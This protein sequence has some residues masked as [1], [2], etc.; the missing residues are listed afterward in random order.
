MGVGPTVGVIPSN[1]AWGET[2]VQNPDIYDQSTLQNKGQ[3]GS[4]SGP[5]EPIVSLPLLSYGSRAAA[6]SAMVAA[7]AAVDV[8]AHTVITVPSGAFTWDAVPALPPGI[9]GSL[10]IQ[11]N[12]SL[13]TL[14]SG[15]PRLFDFARTADYQ[16]FQNINIIGPLT[17]D[18]NN[19]GGQHHVVLG[20]Y[21]AGSQTTGRRTNFAHLRVRKVRTINVPVDATATIHRLNIFIS[22]TQ[23]AASEGTQNTVTDVIVE[24]CRFEGGNQGVTIAGVVAGSVSGLN[25]YFDNIHLVRCWHSMLTA[26]ASGGSQSHFQIGSAA[27]GGMA[28]I[29]DCYG[30]GSG[31][32]G[33]ETNAMTDMVVRGCV[34]EDANI[35]YYHVNYGAPVDV[36]AQTLTY[37][38]C[39]YRRTGRTT[40]RGWVASGVNNNPLANVRLR[41]CTAHKNEPTVGDVTA[42]ADSA[43]YMSANLASLAIEDFKIVWEGNLFG[44]A[45]LAATQ[46]LIYVR[47]LTSTVPI[48]IRNLQMILGGGRDGGASNAYAIRGVALEGL[49]DLDVNGV[50]FSAPSVSNLTTG[51]ISVFHFGA[52]NST[53]LRGAIRRLVVGSISSGSAPRG[54]RIAGTG[55]LTLTRLDVVDADYTAAPAS[56]V[57]F[58]FATAGQN[59]RTVFASRLGLFGDGVD[60]ALHFDGTTAVTLGDGSTLTPSSNIYTLTRD[61]FATTVIVDSGATVKTAG[62]RIYSTLSVANAGTLS[63]NGKDASGATAGGTWSGTISSGSAAGGGVVTNATGAAGSATAAQS[64][65]GAGGGGGGSGTGSP[66]AGGAVTAADGWTSKTGGTGGTAGTSGSAGGA[67]GATSILA[68]RGNFHMLP[69]AALGFLSGNGTLNMLNGGAGGG[70]GAG[71]GTNAGGGGGGGAACMILAAPIVNNTGTISANGGAGGNGAAGNAGGGGGGGAG[72]II[73]VGHQVTQ[74]TVTVTGGAHGTG[75]GSGGNGSDGGAGTTIVNTVP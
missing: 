7:L 74:G 15:A 67:G 12:D 11:F 34:I 2:P 8:T 49:I 42:A 57:P 66:G 69:T 56:T 65:S 39:R 18:N 38:G 71:D 10:T 75:A 16:T 48:A 62:F 14:T 26:Q 53:T 52:S 73:I 13:V 5:Y 23:L 21:V 61:L 43:L 51:A 25:V 72:T 35:G 19:L 50:N 4:N 20:T 55:T 31:D 3:G 22:V 46:A 60:G 44:A 24:D 9:T 37:D 40:G 33:I 59:E 58:S 45:Q 47:G 63:A 6:G 27:Q 30:Y 68:T 64:L 70:A 54:L 17:V 1:G 32:V 41:A 36:N 28:R 29:T